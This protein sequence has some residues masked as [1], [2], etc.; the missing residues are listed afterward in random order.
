METTFEELNLNPKLVEGVYLFGYKKPSKI[1]IEGISMINTGK[2][3][4][5]QS[6]SGTG[7][8][9]TYLLGLLNR[10][11]ENHKLQGLIILPTRELAEQVYNV[12]LQIVQKTK[13]NIILCIGGKDIDYSQLRKSNL[14]IGT[15]GR[16]QHLIELN[17]IKMNNLKLLVLDEADDML[18]EGLTGKLLKITEKL[19]VGIQVIFISAT[20]NPTVFEVSKELMHQPEKIL[21]KK[22][23]VQ[24]SLIS[25][26]YCDVE[27]ENYKFEVLLD[28]YGYISTSQAIIFC[29]TIR[30]VKW[31]S[32]KL[33]ENN[34]PITSIYG[35]MTADE[36]REIVQ[37]FRESKTRLLL[38]TD[39]LA[40]G[41]DIPAVNLVVN[42]D[43]PL[44][45]ETYM[46]RI[47]RCGRFDK[48]GV[49]I[50]FVKMND[51]KDVK[52]FNKM[53]HFYSLNIK[54]MPTDLEK[55]I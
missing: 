18:T 52:V 43:L 45:K 31:L 27:E 37:D 26:F 10:L 55:Y 4:L 54:E 33:K 48:K 20:M 21:L 29:N 3:C 40:R 23:Q 7:K 46:H 19:P 44:S 11:D 38:T 51:P 17:K 53:K 1:Q 2:D 14:L 16:V 12:A 5:I 13:L 49:S 15:T 9:A 32:E 36:R 22:D 39:L 30:K 24:V 47:G 41:I 8:T 42:F 50:S 28:I 35:D 6:Q 34:F 25:Q